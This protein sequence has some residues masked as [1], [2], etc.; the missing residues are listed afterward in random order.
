MLGALAVAATTNSEWLARAAIIVASYGALLSTALAVRQVRQDRRRLRLLP[1]VLVWA[2]HEEYLNLLE[3]RA[4]CDG[5]RPV[6]VRQAGVETVGGASYLPM[7]LIPTDALRESRQQLLN[8]GESVAFY[9][10]V[11]SFEDS[12]YLPKE[13]W[14]Q[15]YG[16]RRYKK[17]F[18]RKRRRSLATA[19]ERARQHVGPEADSQRG[20]LRKSPAS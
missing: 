17:R 11:L 4:I 8:D 20:L 15:D 2:G 19:I 5:K 9:F 12:G 3:V 13:V 14:V 6:H 1:T 7:E 10:D 18:G 16:N